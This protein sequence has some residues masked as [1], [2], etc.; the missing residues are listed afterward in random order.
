[1]QCYFEGHDV[2]TALEP[3]FVHYPHI[4]SKEVSPN[5]EN[6]CNCTTLADQNANCSLLGRI[7]MRDDNF[8]F[9]VLKGN[10]QKGKIMS[11]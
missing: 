4:L 7:G 8:S 10:M 5:F 2:R 3:Q 9:G 6:I 11:T 1:M